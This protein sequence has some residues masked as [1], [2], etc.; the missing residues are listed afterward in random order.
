[1]SPPEGARKSGAFFAICESPSYCWTPRGGKKVLVPYMIACDLSGSVTC[2][3]DTFFS[4][5]P[6]F[7]YRKSKAPRV[8]GNEPGVGD[9]PSSSGVDERGNGGLRS[10]INNG[11]VWVEEHAEAVYVNGILVVRHGDH[12][13]MNEKP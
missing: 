9:G 10:G 11:V 2:S 8:E 13:W 7:L 3:P 1:M 4:G 6:V 5:D 12:C